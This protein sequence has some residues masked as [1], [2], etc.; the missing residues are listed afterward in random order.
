MTTMATSLVGAIDKS[1]QTVLPNHVFDWTDILFNSLAALLA[2]VAMV[3]PGWVRHVTARS[4]TQR[5][6]A[7]AGISR[8][9]AKGHEHVQ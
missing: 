5:S 2:T 7:A 6:V 3:S 9:A 1:I 4:R 8:K